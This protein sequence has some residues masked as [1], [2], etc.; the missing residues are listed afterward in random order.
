RLS[1]EMAAELF[2]GLK[3]QD[4]WLRRTMKP[5][6]DLRGGVLTLDLGKE[7]RAGLELRFSTA[8]K[9]E[10]AVPAGRD[11]PGVPRLRRGGGGRTQ[12]E[13]AVDEASGAEERQKAM[14][15]L[16]FLEEIEK[17]MQDARPERKG[18]VL[19][20]AFA[21]RTDLE[22]LGAKAKERLQQEEKDPARQEER[23]RRATRHQPQTDRP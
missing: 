3:L 10:N 18:E 12:A 4:R 19:H 22:A 6:K 15:W 14:T 8:D 7:A 16:L 13:D 17:A 11:L 9:A 1:E 23:D 2:K 21:A 5:L 20:V